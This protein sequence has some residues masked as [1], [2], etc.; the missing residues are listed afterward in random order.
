MSFDKPLLL[1]V[2]FRG[3]RDCK[4]HAVTKFPCRIGRSND[5]D[6]VISD[7]SVS[8]EHLVIDRSGSWLRAKDVGSSNGTRY[9]GNR[10]SGD[11]VLD[12]NIPLTLGSVRVEVEL[13]YPAV[14]S[15]TLEPL[16]RPKERGPD[17]VTPSVLG[18]F[19]LA[20]L[21][22]YKHD[23]FSVAPLHATVAA[24][25]NVLILLALK[26]LPWIA[27]ARWQRKRFEAVPVATILGT[28]YLAGLAIEIYL[29]VLR[30]RGLTN[31]VAG[32]VSL[33]A[34]SSL[35][36]FAATLLFARCVPKLSGWRAFAAALASVALWFGAATLNGEDVSRAPA[37]AP[38]VQTLPPA[39]PFAA[40]PPN[41]A[42]GW[43]RFGI[44]AATLY[45][46]PKP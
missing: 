21:L 33:I 43:L 23:V 10:V 11:C 3:T 24:A 12:R 22:W 29:V 44:S 25:K 41:D 1:K 4:V 6:I 46:P 39:H 16:P 34:Q 45:A 14:A 15:P 40:A 38:F 2:F 27:L 30:S 32:H 20:A 36:F 42:G 37:A 17:W 13:P 26:T 31:E 35:L 5:S 18:A 19:A 8:S 7:K 9:G 28:S